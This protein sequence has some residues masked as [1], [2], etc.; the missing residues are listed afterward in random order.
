[1]HRLL[2]NATS[3]G[4][5]CGNP[6][7][8]KTPAG[9]KTWSRLLPPKSG[10]LPSGFGRATN[11]RPCPAF[12]ST[13][14]DAPRFRYSVERHNVVGVRIGPAQSPIQLPPAQRELRRGGLC[15]QQSAVADFPGRG[16][17]LGGITRD[18]HWTFRGEAPLAGLL[19]GAGNRPD[20][21]H[22]RS[23]RHEGGTARL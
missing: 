18:R 23:P 9:R 1:M 15:M 11:E 12:V 13:R 16:A 22:Q 4:G 21:H 2:K 14:S 17:L 3:G 7:T 6:A 8:G 19:Y 5:R 20:S 10:G